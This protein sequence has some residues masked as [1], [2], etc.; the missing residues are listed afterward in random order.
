MN[1]TLP[2]WVV[3]YPTTQPFT[4][5]SLTT[6]GNGLWLER[7]IGPPTALISEAISGPHLHSKEANRLRPAFVAVK[8]KYLDRPG[9]SRSVRDG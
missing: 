4:L 7:I 3:I 1:W 9:P 8:G 5:P 6:H 2:T